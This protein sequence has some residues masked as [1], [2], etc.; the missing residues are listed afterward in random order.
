MSGGERVKL[1]GVVGLDQADDHAKGYRDETDV[2][3]RRVFQTEGAANHPFLFFRV[4][5]AIQVAVLQLVCDDFGQTQQIVLHIGKCKSKLGCCKLVCDN[6]GGQIQQQ[7][8][9]QVNHKHGKLVDWL[10]A[11]NVYEN[12]PQVGGG[13]GG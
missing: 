9:Y 13:G 5:N 2:F 1:R 10:F 6:F 3:P 4:L 12:Q 11:S 8:N 7:N